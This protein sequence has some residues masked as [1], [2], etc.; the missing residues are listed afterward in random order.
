MRNFF[1]DNLVEIAKV[2]DRIILLYGDIGNKLFDKFKNNFP[3][4]YFNCGV[5]EANMVGVA[6]GLA[7][8]GF[9]PWVYTINSFLYLKAL[10]QI[11]L[12]VCYPNIP[13]TLVG[14]GGGLGYSELGTTHHSL[15]DFGV[16]CQIPNMK[17]FAPGTR[18]SLLDTMN[19][20]AEN[21]S[22]SYIRI[23]KKES[24]DPVHSL[25]PDSKNYL[26]YYELEKVSPKPETVVISIGTIVE[27]VQNAISA[28][29]K[30]G[31]RIAHLHVPQININEA[32][33][34]RDVV[35]DFRRL[36]IVEE[37]YPLGGLFSQ[38]CIMQSKLKLSFSL[39]RIGPTFEFFVGLGDISEARHIL[40]LDVESLKEQIQSIIQEN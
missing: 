23:G 6:A 16:L 17:V 10:E 40:H 11:K 22:P 35:T 9:R 5:A 20:V 39:H 15:E 31:V 3:T 37:H 36:I 7:K 12:D 38:L 27:N 32:S 2:D 4:R 24:F 26:G 28:L 21:D 25:I 8:V 1:A 19:H 30:S 18:T 34:V 33:I 13:V 14:T 29:N